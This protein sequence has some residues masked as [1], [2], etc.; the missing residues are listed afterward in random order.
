MNAY[1]LVRRLNTDWPA[2]E[3][4]VLQNSAADFIANLSVQRQFFPTDEDETGAAKAL[5]TLQD[6]YKLGPDT[7]SKGDL[8]GTK[9][10]AVLS[11]DDCF[12]MG[13]SAYSE[14]DYYRTVLWME[15]GLK[16]LDAGEEATT[17]KAQVLD[18][19]SY[20]VFQ[21]GGLHRAVELTRR[22]LSLDPSHERAGGNLHYFERLLEEEREKV[23]SKL[24]SQ[25]SK[26][27]TRG[28]W[29]TCPRGMSTRASVVG[30]VSN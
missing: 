25:P 12:G 23:L 16:Q 8:P 20:A 10:Q 11:V 14:G 29:T 1:E 21:W 28:L 19:L 15:R 18:Y 7:I 27:C 5:M 9:Y 4:L 30:R 17:S 26:A 24:S 3:D 13:R 6:T 22:L 2:L